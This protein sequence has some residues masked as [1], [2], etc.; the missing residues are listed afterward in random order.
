MHSEGQRD[1]RGRFNSI[2]EG[3]FHWVRKR[4]PSPGANNYAL[5][6]MGLVEFDKVNTGIIPKT[7]FAILEGGIVMQDAQAVVTSGLG[8]LFSGTVRLQPLYD[9]N[10]NTFG[11][12][13][14]DN[15]SPVSQEFT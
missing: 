12:V 2:N 4:L 5:E 3:F 14:L 11:G 8:G 7:F 1:N 15:N 10:T 9:P 6:S 13:P